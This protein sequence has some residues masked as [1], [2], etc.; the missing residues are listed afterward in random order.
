MKDYSEIKELLLKFSF[1]GIENSKSTGAMLIG[2]APH[3]AE[4]AW[5]NRLY[6]PIDKIEI[7]KLEDGI[8][9]KIPAS[10]VDFLTD[11]SNG[12]NILGDTLCLFGYR[13]NYMRTVDFS[14]QPYSL[15]SLNK[16][17]KPR[18]ST[19]DMLF[20]DKIIG[21]KVAISDERCSFPTKQELLRLINQVHV[22]GLTSGKGGVLHIHLG[23]LPSRMQILL[24]IAREYPTLV[25]HISPTHVGRTTALFEEAIEF[26]SLGGIID[27]STGGTKFDEP[28]KILLHGL[29]KGVSIEQ[30]TF[31]SDGNAG[32]SKKD[33][34]TGNLIF[35]KAPLHLNL[36]QVQKL[37][38]E[39][40]M[41]IEDAIRPV[42]TNPAKNMTLRTKGRIAPDY[43]ADLCFFDN[44]LNLQNVI[45]G[46]TV[47]MQGGKLV[48]AGNFE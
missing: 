48:K 9:K 7:L 35:Y 32:M 5:L 21:C 40:G 47:W 37:V 31:S 36:Q 45:V 6:S 30:M 34:E 23:A 24:E 20:I 13:S 39:G 10:Y 4:N 17:D 8:N 1:L 14:W 25:K 27:I 16:Y 42:T 41:P 18:N 26:A 46:G 15:V 29:E 33:P 28:Y 3:I 22:G 11:F 2:R 44:D 19:E 38:K 12:L 43:D